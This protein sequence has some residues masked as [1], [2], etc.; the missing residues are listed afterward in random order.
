MSLNLTC[1][2]PTRLVSVSGEIDMSNAYL[3]AELVEFVCQLPRP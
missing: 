3:L 2:G 1:D